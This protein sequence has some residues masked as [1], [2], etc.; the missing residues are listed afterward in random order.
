MIKPKKNYR[1][2]LRPG[3]DGIEVDYTLDGAYVGGKMLESIVGFLGK[4][5]GGIFSN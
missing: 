1:N 4:I 5:W 2:F 3:G